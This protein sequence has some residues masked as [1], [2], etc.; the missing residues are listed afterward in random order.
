MLLAA[1]SSSAMAEWVYVNSC[2]TIIGY[3]NPSSIRKNG[4]IVKM[5]SLYDFKTAQTNSGHTFLSMKT[6]AE[7][8][9][10]EKQYRR[11]ADTYHSKNMGGGEEVISDSNTDK[12][13]VVQPNSIADDQ[14]QVACGKK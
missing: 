2:N 5:W 9:C 4:E 8:N 6:Q 12:W 11:L 14:W 3:A 1:V 7:Y 10:K 13:K